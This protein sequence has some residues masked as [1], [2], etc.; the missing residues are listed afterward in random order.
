MAN[1]YDILV[2][3]TNE[4]DAHAWCLPNVRGEGR[5]RW[6]GSRDADKLAGWSKKQDEPG[7]A[8]FFCVSTIAPRRRRKKEFAV[9]LPWIFADVD[10]KDIDLPPEEIDRRLH[11]LPLPPTR[12]HHTGNGIHCFWLLDTPVLADKM[13]VAEVI[14]K[15]LANHLGA[16]IQVAHT[17][18]LLRVPG[19]TNSKRG[20]RKLVRVIKEGSEVYTLAQIDEWLAAERDPVMLR[21]GKQLNAFERMALEQGVRP[22]VDVDARLAAMKFEGGNGTS[23]HETSLSVTAALAA[24]GLAEDEI[25]A[26]V[27]PAIQNLPGTDD[28]NWRVEERTLRGMIRDFERKLERKDGGGRKEPPPRALSAATVDRSEAVVSLNSARSKRD[29]PSEE[30]SM[31]PVA[32]AYSDEALALRF[33]ARYPNLRYTAKWGQWSIFD[34]TRWKTDETREVFSLARIVCR[35]ASREANAA[36]SA[37]AIASSKTR[38]AVVSMVSDDRRHAAT[39]DQWDT[40]PW[41]LN[42]PGGTVDLRTGDMRKH[43]PND[44]A[45]KITSVAPDPV[46]PIPLFKKFLDRVTRS[47]EEY[48]SY[49]QRVSG[50]SLTGLTEEHAMFFF[51]GGGGNGK[52]V[53]MGTIMDVLG[54][55]H[56]TAP[57]ETFTDTKNERHSTELAMLRGARLVTA[58][59]TEDGRN[60]A[61]SKIKQLTGGDKI[62]AR[63]MRQDFFEFVPQFKLMISGNNKPGLKT[64]DD[65]IR[66]RFNLLP[67]TVKITDEEKDPELRAKLK[68]EWPGILAWMIKGCLDWQE[69]GLMPPEVV[70]NATDS[71]LN[72]QDAIAKWVD[73][74]CTRDINAFTPLSELFS[75]FDLWAE[76]LREQRTN[77]MRFGDRLEAMGFERVKQ[78]GRRGHRGIKGPMMNTR[79][80]E[81]Y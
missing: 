29:K 25:V 55:Y 27:L 20:E 54:D 19:S 71:Y 73:Q 48:K 21:R 77:S 16:D 52:G 1:V 8:Q 7:F 80:L 81:M 5:E 42:T 78:N 11:A 53:F 43:D 50:Y 38:S 18:A 40:D 12:M 60:W 62:T 69:R 33:T 14:L 68:A 32:P 2:T 72:D 47:D 10:F 79:S 49:L 22:P 4:G 24:A 41:L 36:K 76:T 37:K 44:Y 34:G 46:C 15:R 67:F 28:W 70:T 58:T 61:E 39:V 57:I 35:D 74:C 26:A 65:A 45:T 63:F 23:V 31:D 30:E 66:R 17:V 3:L 56:H 59:E 51:H 13:E 6:I 64:V 75:A 9:Q